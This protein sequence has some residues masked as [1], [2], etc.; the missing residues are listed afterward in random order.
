MWD[1]LAG[2]AAPFMAAAARG[3]GREVR[4]DDDSRAV[5]DDRES[6]G[7]RLLQLVFGSDGAGREVP[8]LVARLIEDPGSQPR[9]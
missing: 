9:G 5:W 6:V 3:H 7:R 1:F 8:R 4:A 2:E